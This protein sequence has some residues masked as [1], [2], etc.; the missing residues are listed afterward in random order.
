MLRLHVDAKMT[1][2]YAMSVFVALQEKGLAFEMKKVD[3]GA[4][5]NHSA[6]YASLSL[7]HRVP[8]LEHDVF[9]LSESS[10]ITEYLEEVFPGAP[11]YPADPKLKAKAR[12]VQAWIRSDLMPIRLDRS[13]EL[14]FYGLPG[15]PLSPAALASTEVL[16][17]AAGAL[18]ADGQAHLFG[19]WSLA[20]VDLAL[21]LNRLLH[22]GDAVPDAL[23]QYV[24]RQWRHPA[25]QR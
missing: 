3:L 5:A 21:M 19:R 25:I 15:E 12:Q 24:E 8:T 9:A 1:R 20:D 23:A 4:R 17:A 16:Y 18:L 6:S 10:A 11:L 22:A 2:P 13:T 7:T 14:I